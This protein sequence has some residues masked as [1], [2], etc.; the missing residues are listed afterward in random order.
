[1]ICAWVLGR[2]PLCSGSPR[3]HPPGA[4]GP[5]VISIDSC[6]GCVRGKVDSTSYLWK[7]APSTG[8]CPLP[9]MHF[10]FPGHWLLGSGVFSFTESKHRKL[11]F[12]TP[13]DKSRKG[14]C[15]ARL[16][17]SGGLAPLLIPLPTSGQ[18]SLREWGSGTLAFCSCLRNPRAGRWPCV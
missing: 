17:A 14:S 2:V 7:H 11:T 5:H 8:L 16:K 3:L 6:S 9:H 1:M 15:L 10:P 13:Q 18:G 4:A 12:L